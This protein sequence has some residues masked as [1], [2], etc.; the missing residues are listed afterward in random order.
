MSGETIKANAV[1]NC[2]GMWTRQLGK[3]CGARDVP[4][5]AAEH[6]YLIAL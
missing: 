5:Q 1:A 4:N 6:Y 3:R 2:A